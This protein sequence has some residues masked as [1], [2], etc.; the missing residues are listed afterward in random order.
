MYS[1]KFFNV[2]FYEQLFFAIFVAKVDTGQFFWEIIAYEQYH[3][4]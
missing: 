3:I 1:E 4:H 2:Y